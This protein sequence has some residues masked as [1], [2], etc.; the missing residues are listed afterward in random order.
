MLEKNLWK[1]TGNVFFKKSIIIFWKVLER[2]SLKYILEFKLEIKIF[3]KNP[4]FK[5]G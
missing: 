5:V 4:R 3:L 1:E 2:Y